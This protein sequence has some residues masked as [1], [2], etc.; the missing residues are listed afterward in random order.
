[1]DNNTVKEK[2]FGNV[3]S[4]LKSAG[5]SIAATQ[6]VQLVK[7]PIAKQLAGCFRNASEEEMLMFLN[8]PIG[9]GLLSF[10]MAGALNLL[11]TERLAEERAI[12]AQSLRISSYIKVGNLIAS[13]IQPMLM[14]ALSSAKDYEQLTD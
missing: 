14:Q 6:F 10:M 13:A 7:P 11:P 1:M 12:I 3:G 2:V 4:E 8:L 9:E 5:Y